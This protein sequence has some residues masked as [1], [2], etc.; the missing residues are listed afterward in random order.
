MAPVA[1][2]QHFLCHARTWCGEHS[3]RKHELAHN[4]ITCVCRRQLALI[5][6]C[7][8]VA[9]N[10]NRQSF[11]F[12]FAGVDANTYAVVNASEWGQAVVPRIIHQTWKTEVIPERWAAARQSCID[13]HPEWEFKLW[14]DDSARALIAERVPELMPTFDSYIFNIERADAIR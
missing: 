7:I 4:D 10:G 12:K 1:P 13:L 2:Q 3:H 8:R 5:Q 6:C 9:C 11:H 14:T